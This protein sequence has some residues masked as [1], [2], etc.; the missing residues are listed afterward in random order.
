MHIENFRA[1]MKRLAAQAEGT[2]ESV[3]KTIHNRHLRKAKPPRPPHPGHRD[4]P[5][6]TRSVRRAIKKA[7]LKTLRRELKA[8]VKLKHKGDWRAWMMFPPTTR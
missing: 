7:E 1:Y 2:W 6:F 8:A 4:G 5:A 3:K